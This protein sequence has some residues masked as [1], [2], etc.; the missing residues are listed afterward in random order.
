MSMEMITKSRIKERNGNQKFPDFKGEIKI[1]S[2]QYEQRFKNS[3]RQCLGQKKKR[4]VSSFNT[5]KL[6]MSRGYHKKEKEE[7]SSNIN[8]IEVSMGKKAYLTKETP[9]TIGM[10]V[11]S[12][13]GMSALT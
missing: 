8:K 7:V 1:K 4:P 10:N 12:E 3:Q 11:N 13:V 6:M 2:M 5:K 9:R